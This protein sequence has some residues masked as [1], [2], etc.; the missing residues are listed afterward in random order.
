MSI[1]KP[2]LLLSMPQ[3]Q[4]PNFARTV[5]LLC[6]YLPEGAFGIVLNRPTEVPASAMVQLAP[7]IGS[8]NEL[9]LCI[10]GP[11]Q[12][13]RGWIL[14]G[15]PPVGAGAPGAQAVCAECGGV[16]KTED[17]IS[18]GGSHV[19]ANCKPIFLQ[20][21]SEGAA[22]GPRPGRGAVSESDLLARYV[23]EWRVGTPWLAQVPADSSAELQQLAD[24]L[25][26]MA[27]REN[28]GQKALTEALLETQQVEE[29]FRRLFENSPVACLLADQEGR[30]QLINPACASLFGY[31]VEELRGESVERL[32][33]VA[34][35]EAAATRR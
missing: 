31:R 2:T 15:E 4:D 23:G 1:F 14:I 27:R 9:P 20:R 12:P 34:R 8:G 21:L 18:H 25:T 30:I 19:C 24:G 6:D 10:G 5:V 22:L 33:P 3:M 11:V 17:M 7:P 16:F 32:M 28:A 29:Q 35:G 13:D 26:E